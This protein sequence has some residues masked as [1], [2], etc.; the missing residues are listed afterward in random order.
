MQNNFNK[1]LLLIALIVSIQM[2]VK[3]QYSIS[4]P[5]SKFGIGNTNKAGNQVN[6]SMGGIGYAFAK[7]NVVNFLN[8]ASL[9][10]TDTMSFIF[11]IG[12]TADWR[13]IST[14]D[15]HS[16]SFLGGVSNISF[17]FPI[18]KSLKMAL[19]LASVSDINFSTQTDSTITT[20]HYK[21][22]F[23]GDGGLDKVIVGLAYGRELTKN[24][25]FSFGMNASYIFGNIYKSNT[26]SF[27]DSSSYYGARSEV[28]YNV[29]AFSFDLGIQDF[30]KLKNGDIIGFG[31]S[32]TI[33]IKYPTDNVSLYYTFYEHAANEYVQDTI[34]NNR[35]SG[36]I[37]MP[38]SIGIG[39]SYEKPNKLF[40]EIDVNYTQW[41][42][43][44]F[45]KNDVNSY[46]KDSWKA[47]AGIEY[48]PNIYGN[49]IEKLSYRFGLNYD[50]GYLK[51]GEDRISKYGLSCGLSLPIKKLGTRININ[52][53]Y[54]KIGTQNNNLIKENY[55]RIGLSLSAKDR[56]F[57]TRKYL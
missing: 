30:Q 22:I 19:G 21:K 13:K 43:F 4:S 26:V 41:S 35:T 52:F 14:K 3:G 23:E 11:D 10:A 29:S 8:P 37:T 49:Y 27:P 53:E 15:N 6:A 40:T 48:T 46:L 18:T 51:I 33:P 39:L 12:F 44:L 56:W 5:Y 20:G 34:L 47:N 32:Y 45:Q 25:H 16:N 28:N 2:N 9:Y 24:N 17:A 54:G 7:N 1:I 55:Y 38:Q 31:L 36:K 57:V 50:N 42:K